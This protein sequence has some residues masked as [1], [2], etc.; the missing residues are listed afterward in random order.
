MSIEFDFYF[1]GRS[2][3]PP[4]RPGYQENFFRI[5]YDACCSVGCDGEGSSYPGM[6]LTR[7][8]LGDILNIKVSSGVACNFNNLLSDYTLSTTETHHIKISFN[9]TQFVVDITG[10]GQPTYNK[11]WNR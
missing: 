2:N 5:G 3:D 4:N 1:H 10:G 6:F 11:Q 7:S 8:S 9:N